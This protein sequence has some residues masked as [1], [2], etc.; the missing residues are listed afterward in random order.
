MLIHGVSPFFLLLSAQRPVVLAGL[1][2]RLG[3]AQVEQAKAQ[4]PAVSRVQVTDAVL[5]FSDLWRAHRQLADAQAD[6]HWR[7]QRI[8]RKGTANAD[9]TPMLGRARAGL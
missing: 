5:D 4:L 7:G 2:N 3:A 1:A 9:P 8:G 6:Q